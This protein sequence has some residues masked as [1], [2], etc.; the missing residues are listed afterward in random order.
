MSRAVVMSRP[1]DVRWN[2]TFEKSC[3]AMTQLP[4]S[5]PL[6]LLDLGDNSLLISIQEEEKQTKIALQSFH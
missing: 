4:S 1:L 6:Q 5:P 3:K 2:N